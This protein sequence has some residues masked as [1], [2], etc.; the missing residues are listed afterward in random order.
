MITL[1]D[2]EEV[3]ALFHR[4]MGM[5]EHPDVTQSLVYRGND[6]SLQA[7]VSFHHFNPRSCWVDIVTTK[8]F[9]PKELLFSTFLYAFEQLEL[10]R[11]TFF[12]A[13]DNLKSIALV[14]GLGAIREATLQDGCSS[15]TAYIYCLRPNECL[16]WSRFNERRK[17]TPSTRSL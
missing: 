1:G 17:R 3:A 13:A 2:P 16:I 6:N 7:A 11:L 4:V 10:V 8:G 12:V 5:A 15:G 9:L 14:E